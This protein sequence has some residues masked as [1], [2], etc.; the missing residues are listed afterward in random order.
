MVYHLGK[1]GY[2]FR[3]KLDVDMLSLLIRMFL[4]EV[5]VNVCLEKLGQWLM[6]SKGQK[7]YPEMG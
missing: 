1:V 5:E 3:Q 4:R 7:L 2:D 6:D